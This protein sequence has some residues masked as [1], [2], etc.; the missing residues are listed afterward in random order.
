MKTKT[1][2]KQHTSANPEDLLREWYG[3]EYGAALSK[4]H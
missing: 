3:P 1:A 2:K 4:E